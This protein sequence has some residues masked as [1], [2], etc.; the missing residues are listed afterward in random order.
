MILNLPLQN[1]EDI[2]KLKAG[3]VVYLNGTIYTGRDAAHK[4]LVELIENGKEDE[5]PIEL[6]NGAIY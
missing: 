6:N 4:R 5:L 2:L 1:K 3:D